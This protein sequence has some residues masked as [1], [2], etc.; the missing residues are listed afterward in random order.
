MRGRRPRPLDEGS[1][2]SIICGSYCIIYPGRL[3]FEHIWRDFITS[4]VTES[5]PQPKLYPPSEH[6]IKREHISRNAWQVLERLQEAGFE[7]YLVGGGVRDLLVGQRP[8][9]FDV[10]T[11]AHPEQI[12]KVFRNCRLIGRRFRLAHIY[13]REGVIEVATFRAQAG[14]EEEVEEHE[15]RVSETGMLVRDN[16]YGSM[17]DDAWRRDYTINALYYNIADETVVDYTN[18][19]QDLKDRVLRMIGDPTKRFHEDPVRMLRAMRLAAK[20]NFS[21]EPECEK[22]IFELGG[23]LQNVSPARLFEETIK[24]Y[25]CGKAE[26]AF[27]RMREHGLFAVLFPQTEACLVN[28]DQVFEK[29]LALAFQRADER[30]MNDKSLNPAF[31]FAILLWPPLKKAMTQHEAEGMDFFP[32]MFLAMEEVLR[33]QNKSLRITKRLIVV[34]REIWILQHRLQELKRYHKRIY[35]LFHNPRFR[36]AYDFLALRFEAG[37]PEALAA[38][39]WAKFQEASETERN[40]VVA[41]LRKRKND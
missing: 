21:I 34:M 15:H 25:L 28:H 3:L 18:G 17:V 29:L 37:E 24:L 16:V 1:R 32:G 20:L 22:L 14:E 36:A 7:A 19:M 12:Q 10:A 31:M 9:D 23:L 30:V 8:K 4:P 11:N 27:K 6:G 5:Q 40:E 26:D 13:F 41:Q 33:H 35:G 39:W 2:L 38:K